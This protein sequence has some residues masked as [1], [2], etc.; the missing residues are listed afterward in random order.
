MQI[1]K[2]GNPLAP[3]YIFI[4][5]GDS[6][7]KRATKDSAILIMTDSGQLVWEGP[8]VKTTN[9]QKQT[10]EGKPVITYWNGNTTTA[11]NIGHGYGN[12]TFLDESYDEILTVCPDFTLTTPDNTKFPCNLDFHESFI[13][14]RGTI[15]ATAYNTTP[16]DLSP[17]GGPKEGWTFDSG[18]V[19]V[20]PRTEEVLFSWFPQAHVPV[21]STRAPLTGKGMNQ[22]VPLDWFHINSV[23]NIGDNYMVNAR[24]VYSTY[25]IDSNGEIIWH[26][27]GDTGGDFGP[28]PE[29]GNFVSAINNEI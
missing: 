24:H 22:S 8:K 2:N 21:T 11:A 25:L 6:T 27:D 28:I 17:I 15:L 5:P 26:I 29:G 23:V 16:Y 4:Q 9:L 1:T 20:N 7:P 19:E 14:D 18:F 13:T 3:G 10:F 12:V